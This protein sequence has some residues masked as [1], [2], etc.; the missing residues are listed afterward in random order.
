MA[1]QQDAAALAQAVVQKTE[2]S[3]KTSPIPAGP[4]D[5]R[6]APD[7]QL[8]ETIN[9]VFALFRLN[10][11]NQYYA[12]WSDAQ[13]LKQVKRL[14][15]EAL[16]AYPSTIILRAAQ[17][18]IET[19]DYLPTLNRMME[20]CRTSLGEFGLPSTRD[21]Y[22]EACLAPTPKTSAPWSHPAVYLAGRDSD[23]FLLAN[24]SEAK[25]WP[26]FR[27]HYERWA[28]RAARGEPLQGPEVATLAAPEHSVP[29]TE[30]QQTHLA[31]LRKE[32]GL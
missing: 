31:R 27:E 7:E 14:W 12:A 26:V 24:E 11:H 1:E 30:E 16:D 17:R 29:P 15:L 6:E 32:I 3:A 20:A 28:S 13:Q 4:T 19:S 9:Q 23:W 5:R 21:A 22:L 2:A 25:S 18:A 8:V 10:Y